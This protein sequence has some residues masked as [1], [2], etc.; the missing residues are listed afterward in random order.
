MNTHYHIEHTHNRT[1]RNHRGML[2]S[3]AVN[4]VKVRLNGGVVFTHKAEV[5]EFRAQELVRR[6]QAESVHE[7]SFL[8]M[9]RNPHFEHADSSL[10]VNKSHSGRA[11]GGRYSYTVYSSTEAELTAWT[12]RLY[13]NFHP[14]GY[15]TIANPIATFRDLGGRD[16]YQVTA[17]R[18]G[19]CD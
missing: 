11:G 2:T 14:M 7:R 10:F 17:T 5:S 13:G 6:M 16:V 3:E 8:E 4:R 1:V 18:W 9:R 12:E 19:S 15:G